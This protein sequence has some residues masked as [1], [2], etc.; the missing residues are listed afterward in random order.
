MKS[1][2]KLNEI[3]NA[4]TLSTGKKMWETYNN[5]DAWKIKTD[6][7]V[8]SLESRV[9]GMRVDLAQAVMRGEI[10]IKTAIGITKECDGFDYH[11]YYIAQSDQRAWST[12]KPWQKECLDGRGWRNASEKN[13]TRRG[14][15]G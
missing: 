2:L 4:L 5:M 1:K 15:Q 11:S 9:C 14:H 6:A 10:G 8:R 13:M 3:A 7:G 12:A